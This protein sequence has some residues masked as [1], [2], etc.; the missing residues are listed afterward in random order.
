M[1]VR[2]TT[3][4]YV[5]TAMYREAE[6]QAKG[7]WV[8][9]AAEHYG[10]SS[11]VA[12]PMVS[13]C[14]PLYNDKKQLLGVLSANVSL[15]KFSDVIS[16]SIP[17]R[18]AF[19]VMVGKDGRF[20][21][22]PDSIGLSGNTVFDIAENNKCPELIVLGHEMTK[23]RSGFKEVM[24]DGQDYLVNY[25][26]VPDTEWSLALVCSKSEIF[27]KYNR[28]TLIILPIIFLE[29]LIILLISYL[30]VDQAVRPINKL[31]TLTKS[32]A[33]GDFSV[34]IPE[35]ERIDVVGN[36]QNS[37]V[38]M[39]QSL[40]KHVSDVN[41][42]NEE[43]E[44]RN[45]ELQLARS[46][47]EEGIRKKDIFIQ[48][49]THQIRTPLNIILGFAQVMR[50]VFKTQSNEEMK[51]ILAMMS[52]NSMI[53]SNMVLML[54]DSSETGCSEELRSRKDEVNCNQMMRN[55]IAVS[56]KRF[57]EFQVAFETEVSETFMIRC[58][59]TYLARTILELLH[60]AVKF[61]DGK[62]IKLCVKKAE[63]AV[64]II[65]EDTGPGIA[66]DHQAQMFEVF[67][68]LND[69]SEGLG[70]G[71]PLS[72]RHIVMMGGDLIFDTNYHEGCRLIIELPYGDEA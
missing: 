53:L 46:Q 29:L 34:D 8:D 42:L 68:K 10:G 26:P 64:R 2:D 25:V 59:S 6:L 12:G 62:N 19:Y 20:L 58:N 32:I 70:L 66:E 55:C 57:P 17:Y 43:T 13:Y 30:V 27:R 67:A 37:F 71:L 7:C 5:T 51:S 50:D 49:M 28:L 1:I 15:L 4:N 60:N 39:Q 48:N 69:L 38:K 41:R 72:K 31:V 44:Q 61:S 65:I 56:K 33:E 18:N 21:V 47:A 40:R 54:Y 63:K 14:R 45:E 3:F 9:P 16:E 52:H 35:S 23:G 24:V 22:K 36:L 11:F